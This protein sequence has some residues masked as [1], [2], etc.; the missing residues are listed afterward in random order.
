MPRAGVIACVVTGRAQRERR[1]RRARARVTVRDDLLRVTDEL[2]DLVRRPRLPRRDEQILDVNVTCTG[3]VALTW[4]ARV[5]LFGPELLV[6]AHVE[7][8]QRVVV[9]A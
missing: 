3:D 9:Q 5:A 1:Q 6:G 4:I 2:A 7:D 8:R